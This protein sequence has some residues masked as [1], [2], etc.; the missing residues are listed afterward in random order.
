MA[1]PQECPAQV[2]CH[3]SYNPHE[4]ALASKGKMQ[5]NS[6]NPCFLITPYEESNCTSCPRPTARFGEVAR[7]EGADDAEHV[8]GARDAEEQ[9]SGLEDDAETKVNTPSS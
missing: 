9:R 2:Q 8:P 3:E 5:A 6:I 1:T 7:P 4:S